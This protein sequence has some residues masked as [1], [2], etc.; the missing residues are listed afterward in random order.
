RGGLK[1]ASHGVCGT[2]AT[3]VLPENAIH[4]RE[5]PR[6][7]HA[8]VN[9]RDGR[10][11]LAA[12]GRQSTSAGKAHARRRPSSRSVST[13]TVTMWRGP[14]L[15]REARVAMMQS[16]DSRERDDLAVPLDG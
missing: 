16:T 6:V 7:N 11:K 13:P 10:W 5:L 12:S 1:G 2:D 4:G 9:A 8:P 3:A 14:T 15:R